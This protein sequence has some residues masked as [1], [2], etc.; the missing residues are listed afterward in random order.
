MDAP[1]SSISGAMLD[2]DTD[3]I[4]AANVCVRKRK[5]HGRMILKADDLSQMFLSQIFG[6]VYSFVI[7]LLGFGKSY[8]FQI[9]FEALKTQLHGSSEFL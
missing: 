7:M 8:R 3:M 9:T 1:K 2:V 5:S 6:P 4:N